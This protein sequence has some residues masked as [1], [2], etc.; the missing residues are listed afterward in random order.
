ML[1][2]PREHL[3]DLFHVTWSKETNDFQDLLIHSWS[4]RATLPNS[5]T[6]LRTYA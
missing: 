2:G 4:Q 1:T 5:P 6:E 3:A